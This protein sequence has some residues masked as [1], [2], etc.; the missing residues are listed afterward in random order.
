MGFRNL[1]ETT[2]KI[3]ARILV[4]AA[5]LSIFVTIAYLLNFMALD[6]PTYYDSSRIMDNRHIFTNQGVHGVVKIFLQRPVAM[7]TFYVNYLIHDLNPYYFR[8]TN[9]LLLAVTGLLVAVILEL[10]LSIECR[11]DMMTDNERHAI[12][13]TIATLFVAHPLNT[14]ATIYIWQRM[15]LLA[16]LFTY[17]GLAVYLATRLEIWNNARIG[18]TIR[19]LLFLCELLSKENAIILPLIL[20]LA[21]ITFFHPSWRHTVLSCFVFGM[22]T[23]GFTIAMSWLERAHG[24]SQIKDGIVGTLQQYYLEADRSLL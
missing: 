11:R 22:I 20:I 23:V 3:C 21:E 18:Y 16:T 14:Y 7:I 10:L 15:A 4:V 13:I 1:P 6:A 17:A 2:R 5:L 12:S 19:V 8:L 24:T 9:I